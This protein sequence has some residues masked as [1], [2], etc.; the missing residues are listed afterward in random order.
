[1]HRGPGWWVFRMQLG[2]WESKGWDAKARSTKEGEI[3]WKPLEDGMY[4]R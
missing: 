4:I 1:M 2:C 3:D